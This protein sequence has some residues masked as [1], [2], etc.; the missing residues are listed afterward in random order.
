M[1]LNFMRRMLRMPNDRTHYGYDK[2]RDEVIRDYARH[3]GRRAL[4]QQRMIADT[5]PRKKR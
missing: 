4:Q 2:P 5:H 1:P 3:L